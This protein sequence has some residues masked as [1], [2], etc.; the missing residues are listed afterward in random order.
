MAST[1]TNTDQFS[2]LIEA[3]IRISIKYYDISISIIVILLLI[4]DSF[5]IN[6]LPE[7][8]F[9]LVLYLVV[10]II[11]AVIFDFPVVSTI[12]LINKFFNQ[13][14]KFIIKNFL[15]SIVYIFLL[16]QIIIRPPEVPLTFIIP[17][18][19]SIDFYFFLLIFI[20]TGLYFSVYNV[21]KVIFIKAE[22]RDLNIGLLENKI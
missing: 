12:F 6:A 2:A 17:N 7:S 22:D 4:L 19:A 13:Q 8:F 18:F 9:N 11:I 21:V 3:F 20:I 14:S 5:L 1:N 15:K 16:L 10:I